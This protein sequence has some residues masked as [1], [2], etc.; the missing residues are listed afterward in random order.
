[1]TGYRHAVDVLG[2]HYSDAIRGRLVE[3]VGELQ[4]ASYTF[5]N[6]G[7]QVVE[8]ESGLLLLMDTLLAILKAAKRGEFDVRFRW[9]KRELVQDSDDL[10]K[11]A[12][13]IDFSLGKL[14]FR[15][16]TITY[17]NCDVDRF[18]AAHNT[19]CARFNSMFGTVEAEAVD[20]FAQD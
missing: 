18:A 6:G 20:A 7:S 19:K 1:M 16:V 9:V 12:D 11:F 13:H 10:I 8:S 5:A 14:W 3:I 4:C 2:H 17:G 15:R